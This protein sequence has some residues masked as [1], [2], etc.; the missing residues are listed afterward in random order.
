[1]TITTADIHQPDDQDDPLNSTV[2][3]GLTGSIHRPHAQPEERFVE[4]ILARAQELADQRGAAVIVTWGTGRLSHGDF[5]PWDSRARERDVVRPSFS[6]VERLHNEDLT[7][8]QTALDRAAAEL[9][10]QELHQLAHDLRRF[11]LGAPRQLVVLD[12]DRRPFVVEDG[13]TAA[14]RVRYL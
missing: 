2:G 5:I 11:R 1:M 12:V 14:G 3:V 9:G 13:S 7:A 8:S 6:I 10:N 4:R